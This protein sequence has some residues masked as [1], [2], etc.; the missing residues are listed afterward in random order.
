MILGGDVA[1]TCCEVERG[2]VVRTVAVFQLY[3]LP[4]GG[5]CKKLVPK[6]NTHNGAFV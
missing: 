5:E 4:A 2:D 6:T 1:A 3:R